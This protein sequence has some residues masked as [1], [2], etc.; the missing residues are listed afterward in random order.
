MIIVRNQIGP[1]KTAFDVCCE[2]ADK[3]NLPAHVLCLEEYTLSGALE[4]PLHHNERVLETVARWG[5]WDT[6]DRKDNILVLKTDQLYKDIV[7]L[8][9]IK[10]LLQK[11]SL[12]TL[13]KVITFIR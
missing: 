4:R 1:Q 11:Q 13:R 3:A 2:L 7:P 10:I 6:D 9:S 12:T 5:Y 8:A